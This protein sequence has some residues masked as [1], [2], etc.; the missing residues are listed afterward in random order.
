MS[1]IT[2]E[3]LLIF[4]LTVF[5]GVFA[6]SEIAM[7]SARK[8]RLQQW[9]EEGNRKAR[10]A[11]DVSKS[12]EK[13]LSTVQVGITLVGVLAGAFGGATIAQDLATVIGRTPLL[14]PFAETIAVGMVVVVITYVSLILGE[15]VPKRIALNSPERIATFMVKPMNVLSRITS[16]VVWLL[17]A[18]TNALLWCFRFR[19]TSEPT[20]TEE[21]VRILIRQGTDAGVF[22]RDERD[23]VDR[24]FRLGDRRVSAIMTPRTNLVVLYTSD[25]VQVLQAKVAESGH[26]LFPLCE[27]ALDNVLGV[28]RTQ[29][30]LGQTLAGQSLDL[31]AVVRQPLFLPES[32]QSLKLLEEFRKT[33]NDTALLIDEYGGL[34]GL[35]TAT[36]ILKALVGEASDI[37]VP[38]A[39][40]RAD[41]S[42][43][44]DGAL[45]LD[46]L[47]DTL[48]LPRLPNEESRS[49]ETAGGFVMALL[50]RIPAEGDAISW[51]R[52]RFEILDMDGLRVDKILV[53]QLPESESE[54]SMS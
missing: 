53:M 28:V 41:G 3:I 11:L 45:P 38:K 15:L 32:V 35:I 10:L 18:S 13:F 16:P 33:G 14:A 48:R 26:S 25:P 40:R 54:G 19:Q 50:G 44:V 20:I 46:E 51:N 42:W 7:V 31:K 47:K 9:A 24:V 39:R 6:M 21:E 30:I 17:G 4:L 29:E 5:N 49:F 22:E 37:D 43:L 36:D 2:I 12:P 1:T 27:D 8:A 52:Y 34:Q 23:I